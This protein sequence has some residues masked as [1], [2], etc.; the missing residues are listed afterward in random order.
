MPSGQDKRAFEAQLYHLPV[1]AQCVVRFKVTKGTPR[2]PGKVGCTVVM[3]VTPIWGRR[4]PSQSQAKPGVALL[5][6]GQH[7][8][9][10]QTQS[11]HIR[12]S[13]VCRPG[14]QLAAPPTPPPCPPLP[15]A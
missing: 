10:I 14:L 5:H 9:Q 4:P 1:K 8:V 2:Q 12:R 13:F 11:S 7:Q 15:H 6:G 3:L